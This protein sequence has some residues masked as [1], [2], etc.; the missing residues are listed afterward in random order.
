M[1]SSCARDRGRVS[2][3]ESPRQEGG[4]ATG[5]RRRFAGRLRRRSPGLDA[6]DGDEGTR[7]MTGGLW[8]GYKCKYIGQPRR[9]QTCITYDVT[10]C[11]GC[12]LKRARNVD[13]EV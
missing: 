12:S 9:D 10:N 4:H 3:L 2:A 6:C 8:I 7:M 1:V 13:M 5:L 11:A